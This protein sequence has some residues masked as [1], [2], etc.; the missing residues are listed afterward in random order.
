MCVCIVSFTTC[1]E[2][3]SHTTSTAINTFV[4]DKTDVTVVR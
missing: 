4:Y 3:G 1:W 2:V